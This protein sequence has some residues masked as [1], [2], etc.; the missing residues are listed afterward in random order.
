MHPHLSA[1]RG[2]HGD[3]LV[4]RDP[5]QRAGDR[6]AAATRCPSRHRCSR[7]RDGLVHVSGPSGA[8][9]N[10]SG[11]TALSGR[12]LAIPVHGELR[13]LT[14]ARTPRP[15]VGVGRRH[16]RRERHARPSVSRTGRGP[17]TGAR[18]PAGARR[19]SRWCRSTANSSR[20]VRRH[21]QRRRPDNV[22]LGAGRPSGETDVEMLHGRPDRTEEDGELT[23]VRAP[24]SPPWPSFAGARTTTTKRSETPYAWSFA[25][26]FAMFEKRPVT[27]VHLVRTPR[28][29]R[30]GR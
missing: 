23:K 3:L 25:A 16:R 4:A 14:G 22:A 27:H 5:R 9:T 28:D 29:R 24:C 6:P 15:A 2:R 12:R 30:G 26:A 17:R 8:R 11:C 19:Q 7:R 10:W 18:G 20:S 13:H 21:I 1:G